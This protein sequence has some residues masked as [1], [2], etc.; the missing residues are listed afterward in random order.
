MKSCENKSNLHH[1]STE[2]SSAFHLPPLSYPPTP[3]SPSSNLT[4]PFHISN[5]KL[6]SRLVGRKR[7]ITSTPYLVILALIPFS[8]PSPCRLRLPFFRHF[9][10]FFF[11]TAALSLSV[12]YLRLFLFYQK[13]QQRSLVKVSNMTYVYV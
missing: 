3:P 2:L 5:G 10:V 13:Q 8:F 12:T 6:P 4:T 1:C 7:Y 9:S 11:S